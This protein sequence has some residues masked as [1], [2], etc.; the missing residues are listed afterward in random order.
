MS[1]TFVLDTSAFTNL[2]KTKEQINKNIES[3]INLVATARKKGFHS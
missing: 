3:L 1:T 2:G